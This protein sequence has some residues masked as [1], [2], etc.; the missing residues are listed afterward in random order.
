MKPTQVAA[1]PLP[2]SNNLTNAYSPDDSRGRTGI[3][4]ARHAVTASRGEIASIAARPRLR[5]QTS[6]DSHM[7]FRT[8]PL[9]SHE[10]MERSPAHTA[11]TAQ[12]SCPLRTQIQSAIS[13]SQIRTERCR[14]F[15]LILYRCRLIARRAAIA[16]R[17]GSRHDNSETNASVVELLLDLVAF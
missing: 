7:H 12:A 3:T 4:D 16:G 15:D 1:R 2:A 13:A 17:S 6:D 10:Y 14:A 11:F 9:E 5:A 8:P